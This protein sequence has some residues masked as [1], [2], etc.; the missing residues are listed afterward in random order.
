MPEKGFIKKVAVWNFSIKSVPDRHFPFHW[1]KGHGMNREDSLDNFGSTIG[2]SIHRD[3]HFR[4]SLTITHEVKKWNLS[5]VLYKCGL[6][7]GDVEKKDI[8]APP[9]TCCRVYTRSNRLTFH[10]KIFKRCIILGYCGISIFLHIPPSVCFPFSGCV[11]SS[12]GLKR[13]RRWST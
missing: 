7:K 8:K 6:T 10:C 13:V 9:L 3:W 2:N 11:C 4:L 1:K 12:S 5:H